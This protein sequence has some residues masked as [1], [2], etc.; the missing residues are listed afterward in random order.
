MTQNKNSQ[1]DSIVES[2]AQQIKMVGESKNILN[3]GG[4]LISN[5]LNKNN[6]PFSDIKPKLNFGTR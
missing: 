2:T 4:T 6:I 5:I 1:N 3:L